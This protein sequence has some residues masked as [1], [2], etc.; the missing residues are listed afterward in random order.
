MSGDNNGTINGANWSGD[1]A[2]VQPPIQGCT[3]NLAE[4]YMPD[5]VLD[6][7]YCYYP[8]VDNFSLSSTEMLIQWI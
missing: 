8:G 5:A 2:P 3:D 4:N 1:S 6:D 7:G